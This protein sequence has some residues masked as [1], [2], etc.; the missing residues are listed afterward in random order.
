[1]CG[2]TGVYHLD[3]QPVDPQIVV[4]MASLQNHRGPDDNGFRQFTLYNDQECQSAEPGEISREQS[5]A[6]KDAWDLTA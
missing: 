5:L 4:R 1:M 3:R 2:I 6:L